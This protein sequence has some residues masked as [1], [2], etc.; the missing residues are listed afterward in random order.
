MTA[1][2]CC[3]PLL[4]VVALWSEVQHGGSQGRMYARVRRFY[5]PQE[6]PFGAMA[7]PHQLFRSDHFEDRVVLAPGL[8]L[9]KCSVALLPPAQQAQQTAGQA[10]AAGGSSDRGGN[11]EGEGVQYECVWQL[12]HV[13]MMLGVLPPD[14]FNQ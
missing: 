10:G 4:Q 8:V 7:G 2:N 12:D 3:F 9:R 5:R 1:F 13:L 11:G 14:C 6:T